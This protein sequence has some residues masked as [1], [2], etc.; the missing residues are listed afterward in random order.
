MT[1]FETF[2][3]KAIKIVA[4]LALAVL[5][6]AGMSHLLSGISAVIMWPVT[7]ALVVL[8]VKEVL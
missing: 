2:K 1:K 5:A 7:I 8:L 4:V 3:G 6:V